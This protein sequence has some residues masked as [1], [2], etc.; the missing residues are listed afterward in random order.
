MLVCV[1]SLLQKHLKG[2]LGGGFTYFLV[3]PPNLGNIP[4]LTNIFQIT[5]E[6]FTRV[7]NS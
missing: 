6:D 4:I 7:C 5:I 3:S 1:D 2:K